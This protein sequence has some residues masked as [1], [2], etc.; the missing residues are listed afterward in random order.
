V[1]RISKIA[2]HGYILVPV[3]DTLHHIGYLYSILSYEHHRIKMNAEVEEQGDQQPNPGLEPPPTQHPH[4]TADDLIDEDQEEEEQNNQD[5]NN[6]D[7]LHFNSMTST[8]TL[9][10]ASPTSA[11]QTSETQPSNHATEYT[12]P[13]SND[14]A[15]FSDRTTTTG[16]YRGFTYRN[17]RGMVGSSGTPEEEIQL[18]RLVHRDLPFSQSRNRVN[19]HHN[20]GLKIFRLIRFDWFHVILRYPKGLCLF[21]LIS[22]WTFVNIIF[23][24][25]YVAVDGRI[26][27]VDCGLGKVGAPIQ[28][29][30]AFAFSIET[31]TTGTI[32]FLMIAT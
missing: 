19:V 7:D 20:H 16:S 15:T 8:E 23:A 5:S 11:N 4:S 13:S 30:Q 9:K 1:S 29:G 26:P 3:R 21:A 14:D 10:G 18:A 24:F 28:F 22:M 25:I 6:D 31:A 32:A 27:T 12:V 17:R 2:I